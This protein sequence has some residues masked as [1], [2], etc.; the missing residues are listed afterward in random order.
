MLNNEEK[1]KKIESI[2]QDIFQRFDK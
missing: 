1:K 2:I